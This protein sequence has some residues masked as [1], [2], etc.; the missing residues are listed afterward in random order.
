MRQVISLFKSLQFARPSLFSWPIGACAEASLES[1]FS[2]QKIV[3][4]GSDFVT[5]VQR[6]GE[7]DDCSFSSKN[8]HGL[9]KSDLLENGFMELV[10]I[11]DRPAVLAAFGEAVHEKQQVQVELRL[12]CHPNKDTGNYFLWIEL[13]CSSLESA[14][15]EQILCLARDISQ[16]KE[17]EAQLIAREQAAHDQIE[18]KTRLL[19]NMS[20]ELRTPLNTIIGFSQMM[21]LPGVTSQNERQ[22][23]EYA[24]IIF[25]SGQD[26]LGVVDEVLDMS[27]FDAGEYELAP[28]IFSVSDLV[29]A[30]VELVQLEAKEKKV[31][32]LITSHE[33]DLQMNADLAAC[34]QALAE[35]LAAQIKGAAGGR[36]H[37]KVKM[38]DGAVLFVVTASL[39]D[40][41]G[42][43]V[44]FKAGL[45]VKNLVD[46]LSGTL[47]VTDSQSAR[48]EVVLQLPQNLCENTKTCNIVSLAPQID[49]PASYLR[50]TA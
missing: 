22:M 1:G 43:I 26:L 3:R 28:E 35:L 33:D 20:H 30:S 37:L 17:R 39:F 40:I 16:W 7:V 15:K 49:E 27:Q 19:V 38:A 24:G 50:K 42:E 9:D 31:R 48:N 14:G 2:L 4:L 18:T 23:V 12:R 47:D 8:F 5:V 45:Q 11:G 44:G 6:T 32:F 34:K 13:V 41:G 21:K 29:S 25:D 36:V 10:H 46:V